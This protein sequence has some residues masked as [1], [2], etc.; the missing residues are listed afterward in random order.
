M[1]NTIVHRKLRVLAGCLL[2]ILV[3]ILAGCGDTDTSDTTGA[4]LKT[5]CS[6]YTDNLRSCTITMPDTRRVTCVIY[7][8]L[9]TDA[10][11][12][13]CDWIHADGSD[14]MGAES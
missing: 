3:G 13:S 9:G 2:I 6:S 10:S 1:I 12:L 4:A 8:Q 7:K 14:Y 11:G 5:E